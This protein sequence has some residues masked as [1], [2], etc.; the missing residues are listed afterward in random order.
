M[1]A[2]DV[3]AAVACA[4][5]T[6]QAMQDWSGDTL[7][8]DDRDHARRVLRAMLVRLGELAVTGAADPRDVVGGYVDLLLALRARARAAKDFATSDDVRDGLAAPRR[9]GPRR[10]GGAEWVIAEPE[11]RP[12]AGTDL[13]QRPA[14]PA[15]AAA[16]S[17]RIDP[18]GAAAGRGPGRRRGPR[19]G[20]RVPGRAGAP[21]GVR[22]VGRWCP[23]PTGSA[24]GTLR[25]RRPQ[26]TR[27]PVTRPTRA[28]TTR[29]HGL[30][31]RR[32]RRA[33]T[34]TVGA[35]PCGPATAG[36]RRHGGYPADAGT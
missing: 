24:D 32:G 26:P 31:R 27:T 22:R 12:R 18:L 30:R 17:A 29:M 36:T 5:A 19:P 25:R 6:E 7:E 14:P 20:P 16:L 11:T 33:G 15:G 8:S 1:Q 23:G 21:P 35:R 2:Q 34:C 13:P 4:L 3:E 9:R 28:A 10:P